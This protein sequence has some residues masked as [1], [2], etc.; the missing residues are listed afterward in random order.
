[1]QA[2]R[3]THL[4]RARLHRCD[5]CVGYL[6]GYY[7]IK[8]LKGKFNFLLGKWPPFKQAWKKFRKSMPMVTR[9]NI[10]EKFREATGK[11]LELGPSPDSWNTRLLSAMHEIERRLET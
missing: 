3:R 7:P 2:Q 5:V 11:T 6:S 1:M 4:N 10:A 8:T 9:K